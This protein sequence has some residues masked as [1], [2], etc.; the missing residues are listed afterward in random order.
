MMPGVTTVLSLFP[1]ERVVIVVLTNKRSDVVVRLGQRLAAT[2]MP[3]YGWRLRE[4]RR[5]G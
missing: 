1:T 4:A 5:S 2:V 3:Q